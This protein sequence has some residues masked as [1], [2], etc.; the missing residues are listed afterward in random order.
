M[1]FFTGQ[2]WH[3]SAIS[4]IGF[5]GLAPIIALQNTQVDSIM[6][7]DTNRWMNCLSGADTGA[8]SPETKASDVCRRADITV[9][10]KKDKQFRCPLV[11]NTV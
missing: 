3:C 10:H 1:P 4:N 11:G 8:P 5:L 7:F 6:D 9:I 2:L